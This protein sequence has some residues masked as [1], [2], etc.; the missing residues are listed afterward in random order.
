MIRGSC[1]KKFL[2]DDF[3]TDAGGGG[4]VG[5][6]VGKKSGDVTAAGF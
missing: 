6:A 5:L 2:D 4:V 1:S 3:C